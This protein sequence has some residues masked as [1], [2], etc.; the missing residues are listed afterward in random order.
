MTRLGLVP[1]LDQQ[2]RVEVRLRMLERLDQHALDFLVGQAVRRLDL[3][4]LLDAGPQLR[5]PTL[6]MPLASI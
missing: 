5:A 6:R 3:D 4:R 1:R 2:A